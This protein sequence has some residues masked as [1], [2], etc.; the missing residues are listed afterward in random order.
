[1]F[2][3]KC[4]TREHAANIW[5]AK[6]AGTKAFDS[7]H[8][9]GYRF[10]CV[11]RSNFL[12]HR[13]IWKVV[14]GVDPKDIDHISG[15]KADNRLVNLRAAGKLANAKNMPRPSN[16]TSGHIGVH[17]CK[18]TGRWRVELIADGKKIRVGRFDTLEE[19]AAARRETAIAHGFHENHGR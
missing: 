13:I 15:N 16:N 19:A 10:G 5:N 17:F 14:H 4:L 8:R 3:G 18:C 12:A 9:S 6:F 11:G 1:M 2:S 7:H